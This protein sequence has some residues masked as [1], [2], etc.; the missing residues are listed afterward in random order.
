MK[1]LGRF[2]LDVVRYFYWLWRPA[3][4]L[5]I[6][7]RGGHWFG[8]SVIVGT[9]AGRVYRSRCMRC[10]AVRLETPERRRIRAWIETGDRRT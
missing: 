1:K 4:Q 8:W 6:C 5:L 3:R 2:L 10:G 7:R 9:P